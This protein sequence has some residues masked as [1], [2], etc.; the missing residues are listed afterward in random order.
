MEITFKGKQVTL[1]GTEVHVGDKAP[2]FD[3]TDNTLGNVSLKDTQGKRIFVVV[4]SVDTPVCDREIRRFNEEAA[5]LNDVTIYVISM[6]LP[7]AQIRWCGGAG[8]D[9]VITLSDY[10][11]R[12]FGKNY[13]VYI[14]ELGLLARAIFVVD[15]DNT[16]RHVE[17]CGEVSSDPDYEGALAAVKSL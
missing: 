17:Y 7:F 4:P 1:E 15:E 9:K 12:D 5:A 3:L 13:G 14:K 10:K 2:D 6:D 16:V 8:V 11:Q